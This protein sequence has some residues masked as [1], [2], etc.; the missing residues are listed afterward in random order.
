MSAAS[1]IYFFD[2]HSDGRH[3]KAGVSG[4]WASRKRKHLGEGGTL[5]AVMLGS[6]DSEGKLHA[7]LAPH[8]APIRHQTE[9]YLAA[10]VIPY[11]EQLLI[12]GYASCNDEDLPHLPELPWAALSPSAVLA[13][14]TG[15]QG[16]LFSAANLVRRDGV[17]PFDG[18]TLVEQLRRSTKFAC[19]SSQTDEWYTPPDVIEAARDTMG[20]IDLDPASCPAANVVVRASAYYSERVSGLESTHPWCG[21]VWMNPPYSG[22]A[23]A[24]VDRL[25]REFRSGAVTQAIALLGSQALVTQWA[26][27]AIRAASA[28]GIS[29]GRW[30]FRPGNGQ[31]VSSPA[32]G[33]SLLYFGPHVDR[34]A[35]SFEPLAHV[36]LP[37]WNH[38]PP[39]VPVDPP[40]LPTR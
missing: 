3:V 35:R 29:R 9:V 18:M 28:I 6:K 32:G 13:S 39:L 21:R 17:T 23:G 33:S 30:E 27:P 10:P 4:R 20:G 26:D 7:E 11:V 14:G 19:Y 25:V 2:W 16:G 24:F 31:V 38:G 36:L 22:N 8:L 37:G 34:F 1:V 5:L 12:R 15:R 40:G